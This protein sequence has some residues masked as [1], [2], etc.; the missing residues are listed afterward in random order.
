MEADLKDQLRATPPSGCA[1]TFA[2]AAACDGGV[3]GAGSP[4]QALA[5]PVL[6][7]R[8]PLAAHAT[9]VSLV[10]SPG[11]TLAAN[12]LVL[13]LL[14]FGPWACT[15]RD[16]VETAPF[17]DPI[18]AD[19]AHA[20]AE[21]VSATVDAGGTA[22][23]TAIGVD[24]QLA[25]V[26]ALVDAVAAGEEVS[27][28]VPD[29]DVSLTIGATACDDGNACTASDLDSGAGCTGNAISCDDG[30]MCTSDSC[31][32]A[33][34]CVSL[35]VAAS[36][37]SDG[38]SCSLE[39][40]GAGLCKATGALA[41][42]N[43]NN[44]CTI[45]SCTQSKCTHQPGPDNAVCLAGE[46][47][48][49]VLIPAGE[50]AVGY[51][52]SNILFDLPASKFYLSAFRIQQTEVTVAQ[53]NICVA[54]G[55]CGVPLGSEATVAVKP[56]WADNCNYGVPGR[57]QHPINCFAVDQAVQF[58]GWLGGRLPTDPEYDKAMRG[59]CEFVAGKDCIVATP[60]AP[61]GWAEAKD[62]VNTAVAGL[63]NTSTGSGCVTWQTCPVNCCPDGDSPYG[64]AG[65]CGNANELTTYG[66]VNSIS[67]SAYLGEWSYGKWPYV[68]PP[69]DKIGFVSVRTYM[70]VFTD[71][72]LYWTES[73][74]AVR[75]PAYSGGAAGKYTGMAAG[76]DSVASS[77]SF[78]C[79]LPPKASSPK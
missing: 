66:G 18:G 26:A 27:V 34:G 28:T 22:T 17:S 61:W 51:G 33:A 41:K 4:I 62:A 44:P 23:A 53:Y 68:D 52:L 30:N 24:A 79:T 3:R 49:L 16:P 42:C 63:P 65:M 54:A 19:P 69:A 36:C 73:A 46:V 45:D 39:E 29:A 60:P 25:D 72:T 47:T 10:I 6:D 67:N 12:G 48:G 55:A 50:T 35:P 1:P 13:L 77:T 43:D 56:A 14:A 64:I 57:E 31:Q 74:Y 59:G 11:L 70:T 40:C 8:A 71:V 7:E 9:W 20:D 58:C 21:L 15:D 38:D 76:N 78:R 75:F 5:R 32:P 2:T 37:E